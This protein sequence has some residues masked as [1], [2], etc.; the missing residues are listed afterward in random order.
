MQRDIRGLKEKTFDLL[1][2]GG[3][4]YGAWIAWEGVSRGLS[5]ALIEK[6][7]FCSATS[8][9]TN[10][11]I[12]GGI[13]YIK[14]GDIKR[15]RESVAERRALLKI[16][17]HLVS[18][19][20]FV[21][22]TY[23][24][25]GRSS[26]LM[27]G[28]LAVND[29]LA[30]DRNRGLT[31]PQKI[32]AGRL[33]SAARTQA[34]LPGLDHDGL[35][36]GA[37]W[38]DGFIY[39][40]ERL[41]F[42]LLAIA[43]R[44]GLVLAN[45]VEMLDYVRRGD[46]I[47]GVRAVDRGSGEQF[48]ISS[49]CTVNALGPWTRGALKN[50]SLS[51]RPPM[52]YAAA[53]NLVV[54][55]FPIGDTSIGIWSAAPFKDED[56]FINSSKRLFFSTPWRGYAVIGTRFMRCPGDAEVPLVTEEAVQAFI[57]EINV[58]YPRARITRGQV[59]F[60]HRGLLPAAA[61][62]DALRDVQLEKH[63][64]I[65]DHAAED[66]VKGLLSVIGVKY[67]TARDVAEKAVTQAARLLGRAIVPSRSSRTML[68][69]EPTTEGLDQHK[70]DLPPQTV[71]HLIRYYGEDARRVM[72]LGRED[73]ALLKALTPTTMTIGAQ[74][75]YAVREEC[76][77]TLLDVILRRTGDGAAECPS[78][79]MLR[80]VAEI[81]G[82]DLGWDEARLAQEVNDV[83]CFYRSTIEVDQKRSERGCT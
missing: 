58:A 30:V 73:K 41:V 3:G 17:S 55:G 10:K 70:Y 71:A 6:N 40:S 38:W 59:T 65:I 36:G 82:R 49:Q 21:I 33:L 77:A 9:Q 83:L 56:S 31:E 29:L 37:M 72:Q 26:M 60:V 52:P 62:K 15:I 12:H 11:I 5:V 79:A 8:A 68:L 53:M 50:I 22:P 80:V 34:L 23:K 43:A 54:K 1:V 45:Y 24:D 74:V 46:R 39:D 19:M 57:D 61:A 2:I 13:R 27:R 44:Q 25:F 66:G 48:A 14:H 18:P 76:A 28:V 32:P 64:R 51:K 81:M 47:A 63:Y 7:D 16:A 4:I 42:Q 35:T 67:T 78:P 75:T 69:A 20:P